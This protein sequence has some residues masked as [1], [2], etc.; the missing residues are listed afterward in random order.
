MAYFKLS[1]QIFRTVTRLFDFNID[2]IIKLLHS[3]D[4]NKS[5]GC[6]GIPTHMSKFCATSILKPLHILFKNNIINVS[7]MI[8]KKSI[9]SKFIKTVTNKSQKVTDLCHSC[10][11][12]ATLLKILS[13]NLQRVINSL[14][15]I[16][17]VSSPVIHVEISC[18]Q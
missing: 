11:F 14:F 7:Q 2:T 16:S 5:Q 10:L 17:Q 15:T 12:V 1:N 4:P 8:G 6:D 18:C 13:L 9:S 3:L